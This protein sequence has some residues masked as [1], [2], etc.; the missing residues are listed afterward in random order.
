MTARQSNLLGALVLAVG[1]R[2]RDVTTAEARRGGQTPAALAVLA[3]Q[4]G[5]GIEGL[6]QQLNL[7]QPATVRLVN[8]LVAANLAVRR[9]GADHRSVEVRLTRA[10]RARADAVLSGRR[11]VLDEVLRPLRA[12]DRAALEALLDQ[13]LGALTTDRIEA[14]VI[15]RLCDLGA[16][17]LS[18]CPVE[19]ALGDV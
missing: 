16:C 14:E 15:C 12:A 13:V 17:E 9:E 19:C 3:Q 11:A 7:S 8:A 1:D 6:R 18:R 5:L 4:E 2:L 10:G